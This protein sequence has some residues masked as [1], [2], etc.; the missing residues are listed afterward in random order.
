MTC[1]TCGNIAFIDLEY[2]HVH[3]THKRIFMP[4]EVGVA[5]YT[6]KKDV[7]GYVG[8]K[9]SYDID[10]ELWKNVIDEYGNTIGETMSITNY[11]REE[12]NKKISETRILNNTQKK[13]SHR[14]AQNAF[15]NLNIFMS[16]V[17]KN[18]DIDK[19]VFFGDGMEKR[20]FN[21]ARINTDNYTWIDLQSEIK[22]DF[23]MNEYLSLDKVSRAI[24]FHAAKSSINSLNFKYN[25]PDKFK[26]L[27]K[28][29]KAI[30]DTARIFLLYK[31]YCRNPVDFQAVINNHVTICKKNLKKRNEQKTVN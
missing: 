18:N 17:L 6:E 10:V 3:G 9:F 30:G 12:Y 19:L 22:N 4:I 29:H 1:D 24:E 14:I 20:A 16:N 28:P 31:E 25:T 2:G 7:L 27:M 13:Q 11:K 8:K 26:Y 23:G 21:R 5:L 15:N